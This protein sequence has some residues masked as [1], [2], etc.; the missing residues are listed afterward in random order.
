MEEEVTPESIAAIE[1]RANAAMPG[2]W[3][4][5]GDT[6]TGKVEPR[7]GS[8]EAAPGLCIG[9]VQHTEPIA[10]FSGYLMNVEANADFVVAARTDIPALIA[11]IRFLI[12]QNDTLAEGTE[13]LLAE[14]DRARKDNARLANENAYLIGLLPNG[15]TFPRDGECKLIE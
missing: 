13:V 12:S 8:M 4:R 11:E 6:R 7:Q 3:G 14:L 10:R 5:Y 2:P 9:S 1:A 15:I